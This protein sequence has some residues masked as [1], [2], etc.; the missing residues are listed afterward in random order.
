MLPFQLSHFTSQ[1]VPE[2][3]DFTVYFFAWENLFSPMVFIFKFYYYY[4]ITT[5]L[6]II[7]LL[8][9]YFS[10]LLLFITGYCI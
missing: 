7:W 6:K 8:K 3:S 1:T 10:F 4:I 9:L 5:T 2:C